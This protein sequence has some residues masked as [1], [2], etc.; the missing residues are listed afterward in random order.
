M[1]GK[2]GVW[3]NIGALIYTMAVFPFTFWPPVPKPT[4]DVMNW[5][6]LMYGAVIILATVYYI[7][8]GRKTYTLPQEIIEEFSSFDDDVGKKEASAG[9]VEEIVERGK[10]DM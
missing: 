3:V 6:C 1:L 10:G 2:W 7:I 5:S 4:L 8:H 9:H